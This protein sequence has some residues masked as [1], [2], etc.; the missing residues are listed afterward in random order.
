MTEIFRITIAFPDDEKYGIIHH[1]RRSAV[2]IPSNIAEDSV[3]ISYKE[4]IYFLYVA[5][6]SISEL[7]TQLIIS[8]IFQ[9][10]Y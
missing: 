2:F 4:K 5:P 3:R 7:E 8:N 9:K 6:G 1:M 10:N